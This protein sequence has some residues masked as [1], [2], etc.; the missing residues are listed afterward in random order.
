MNLVCPRRINIFVVDVTDWLLCLIENS[1]R[2]TLMPVSSP[3]IAYIVSWIIESGHCSLLECCCVW[4]K[5]FHCDLFV[6][7]LLINKAS[8]PVIG[9][10]Y[11][12]NFLSHTAHRFICVW[13]LN[14][15]IQSSFHN[16]VYAVTL[17]LLSFLA[18]FLVVN[19][20]FNI[21][22]LFLLP[23]IAWRLCIAA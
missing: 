21:V 8:L 4:I 12:S 19:R 14:L 1:V 15:F 9:L 3:I 17:L 16:I 18:L 10:H 23:F 2:A 13:A 11:C 6:I 5:L 22:L 7:V 20:S